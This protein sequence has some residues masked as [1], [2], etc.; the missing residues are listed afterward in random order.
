[1]SFFGSELPQ[2]LIIKLS[3]VDIDLFIA[4]IAFGGLVLRSE[5]EA[6]TKSDNI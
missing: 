3:S 2:T 5:R 1:M 4:A 6:T